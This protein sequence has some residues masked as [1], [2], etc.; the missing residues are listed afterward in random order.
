MSMSEARSASA[1]A[2]MR[3]TSFVANTANT[4]LNAPV[5]TVAATYDNGTQTETVMFGRQGQDAYASR[6][7]ESGALQVSGSAVDEVL[8]A[9][10]GLSQ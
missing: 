6:Q 4:G 8:T 1:S 5:L 7:D 2:N 10:D 9:L 3:V